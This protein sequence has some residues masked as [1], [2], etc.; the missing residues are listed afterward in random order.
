MNLENI[1]EKLREL[2]ELNNKTFDIN[3]SFGVYQ[4]VNVYSK[5]N[6]IN[7]MKKLKISN[8]NDVIVFLSKI[9]NDMP[10]ATIKDLLINTSFINLRLFS[11]NYKVCEIEIFLFDLMARRSLNHAKALFLQ[12][13]NIC[14]ETRVYI[15]KNY[16][17][18]FIKSCNNIRDITKLF[19][20]ISPYGCYN[21][22]HFEKFMKIL[23]T[24]KMNIEK[25][26]LLKRL[27]TIKV[28]D[29]VMEEKIN[30]IITLISLS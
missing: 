15:I 24:K 19:E 27:K 9:G 2:Q 7:I 20:I 5:M 29:K 10:L 13:K 11:H 6:L 3:S 22:S 16:S 1:G 30:S 28:N 26:E 14:P 18:E 12:Y 21:E 8:Y 4:K 23:T 17:S 25:G